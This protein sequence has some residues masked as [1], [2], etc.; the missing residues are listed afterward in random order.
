MSLEAFVFMTLGIAVELLWLWGN[1]HGWEDA[2][3]GQPRIIASPVSMHWTIASF[4]GV[5]AVVIVLLLRLFHVEGRTSLSDALPFM[6]F[7][8]LGV[9]IF[10]A[11]VVGTGLL[12]QV[13]ERSII[14]TQL[15]VLFGLVW[16]Q[17]LPLPWV[18]GLA[19]L[20][21][22]LILLLVLRQKPF[23]PIPKAL[24]YFWY[25]M[26]L[27][28]QVYQDRE[29]MASFSASDPSLPVA[30]LLGATLVF[31]I[32]HGL[33]GVRFL[34]IV[35]SLLFP[36]NRAAV[37][38]MMPRLFQDEQVSPLRF[39]LVLGG[40]LA[41]VV[42]LTAFQVAPSGLV[43]NTAVLLSVQLLFRSKPRQPELEVLR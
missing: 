29:T 25:L 34:L 33:F 12:P 30:F 8:G 6:L 36:R 14:A 35:S 20:P 28:V 18:I 21:V 42:G 5:I 41:L 40:M 43:L 4:L 23:G 27:M 15:I 17:G 24:L 2:P 26:L 7:T 19:A 11:G 3:P 10:F 1:A 31:L 38:L 9:F 32:L 22:A 16:G 39:F 37:A 13:N